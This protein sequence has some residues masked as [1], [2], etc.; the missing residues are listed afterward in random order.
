[1]ELLGHDT[2]EGLAGTGM[3][4]AGAVWWWWG[5]SKRRMGKEG[6]GEKEVKRG[7]ADSRRGLGMKR[8]GRG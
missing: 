6:E 1:M 2:W 4:M 8:K 5:V 3:Q 7:A